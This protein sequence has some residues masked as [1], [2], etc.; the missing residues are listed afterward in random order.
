MN[1][2]LNDITGYIDFLR[3]ADYSVM[4][5]CFSRVLDRVLPTLINYEPHLPT[6]CSYLKSPS[7]MRRQCIRNKDRLTKSPPPEMCYSC[8]WAGVEEYI[9]PI[10]SDEKLICCIHISGFRGRLPRSREIAK[11][12][13]SRLGAGFMTLYNRLSTEVPDAQEILK[14]INPLKYMFCVLYDECLALGDNPGN[15]LKIYT[16]TIKYINDHYA[17]KLTVYDIAK[18]QNYSPSYLRSIF[19]K[20][21]GKTVMEHLNTVRLTHGAYLL[22]HTDLSVIDIAFGCG[23]EDSNYFSTAFKKHFGMPPTKYRKSI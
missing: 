11:K 15:S 1:N 22:K 17:E 16:K 9:V 14:I 2:T 18:A 4:L 23:F 5:S 7:G 19:V 6:I 20:H 3:S 12:R 13:E 10:K 8:C 21:G